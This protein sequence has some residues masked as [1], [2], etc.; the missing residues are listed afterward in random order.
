MQ[1]EKSELLDGLV[2]PLTFRILTSIN[3]GRDIGKYICSNNPDLHAEIINV[4]HVLLKNI[5]SPAYL[6]RFLKQ[7]VCPWSTQD[8][9]IN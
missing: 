7:G 3:A 5:N 9:A 6:A 2:F 4:G 8:D 1:F